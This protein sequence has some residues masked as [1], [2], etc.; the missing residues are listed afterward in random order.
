MADSANH[1]LVLHTLPAICGG[2]QIEPH[3]DTIAALTG[4]SGE[5][6][7][8]RQKP[9]RVLCFTSALGRIEQ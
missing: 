6:W 9:P 8:A 1:G 4:G 3:P 5:R 7:F 2:V